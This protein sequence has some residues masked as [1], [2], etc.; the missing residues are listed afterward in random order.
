MTQ[1]FL[2][3]WSLY[4]VSSGQ[5]PASPIV[6]GTGPDG[7]D[8]SFEVETHT[9]QEPDAAQ[10][11]LFNL[12]PSTI[13]AIQAA[14]SVMLSAGYEG[15]EGEIYRGEV[16]EFQTGEKAN[17]N[18]AVLTRLWCATAD[19]GYNHA[20]LNQ[21][22]AAG[23]SHQDIVNACL[24][25][26]QSYGVTMGSV[27]GVNLSS[28]K[29]PRGV[30]LNGLA[31]DHLRETCLSLGATYTLSGNKLSILSVNA[32]GTGPS[33][34]VLD[35]DRGLLSQPILRLE[36]VIADCLIN[37]RVGL[38]TTVQINV[39]VIAPQIGTTGILGTTQDRQTQLANRLSPNGQY[40]VIHQLITGQARGAGSDWR[41]RLTL[42]ASGQGL[43]QTQLGLGYS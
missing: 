37:P 33:G 39:P 2:R 7:L 35:P 9:L 1:N 40:R 23:A 14:K 26:L 8:V 24:Q 21:T 12:S 34:V 29:F 16:V 31:R 6:S 38:N 36:G 27:V 22:L 13:S 32:S 42:V 11:C 18:T 17:N 30:V 15:S 41:M 3:S 19:R 4:D 28:F 20:K 25:A 43:N 5:V 10:I